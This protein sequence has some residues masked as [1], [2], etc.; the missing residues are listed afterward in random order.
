MSLVSDVKDIDT[1]TTE[2]RPGTFTFNFNAK[3][4]F[5]YD[6]SDNEDVNKTD[7][8]KQVIDENEGVNNVFEYKDTLFFDDNDV[9]FNGMCMQI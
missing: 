4:A 5:K 7:I 9:R 3:N 6:S 2:S 8:D 1:S